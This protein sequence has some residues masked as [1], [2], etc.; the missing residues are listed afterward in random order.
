[1]ADWELLGNSG[2]KEEDG[3]IEQYTDV[4]QETGSRLAGGRPD[5]AATLNN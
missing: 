2:E 5:A 4:W 3:E 1:V